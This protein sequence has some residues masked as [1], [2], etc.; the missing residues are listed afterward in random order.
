MKLTF[1]L[2]YRDLILCTTILTGR[3]KTRFSNLRTSVLPL[4]NKT[5]F[6]V[7]MRANVSTPHTTFE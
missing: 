6:A 3:K 7:D 4:Q 1:L 5:I 2:F